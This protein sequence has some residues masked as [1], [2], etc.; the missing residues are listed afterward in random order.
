MVSEEA[1]NDDN[2]DGESCGQQQRKLR[3]VMSGGGGSFVYICRWRR[4]L[5]FYPSSMEGFSCLLVPDYWNATITGNL[6]LGSACS[7]LVDR[8]I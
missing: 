4:K 5:W 8:Y 1:T 3:I 6:T 7:D 2:S